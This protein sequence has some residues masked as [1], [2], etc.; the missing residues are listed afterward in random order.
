MGVVLHMIQFG[1]HHLHEK[2]KWQLLQVNSSNKLDDEFDD[3]LEGISHL[4]I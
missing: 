3:A 4:E 2:Y 1:N